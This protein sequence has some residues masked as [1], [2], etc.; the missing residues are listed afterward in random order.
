MANF[1]V[2]KA[3]NGYPAYEFAGVT[4]EANAGRAA[5][6][7]AAAILARAARGGKQVV[8]WGYN[9]FVTV[10]NLTEKILEGFGLSKLGTTELGHDD[11]NFNGDAGLSSIHGKLWNADPPIAEHMRT[12]LSEEAA[13]LDDR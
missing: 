4:Q 10:K 11:E 1:S 9:R 2:G 3:Q 7:I 6:A 5:A 8:R 12:W 13:K